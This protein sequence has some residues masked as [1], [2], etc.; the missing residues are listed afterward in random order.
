MDKTLIAELVLG[1]YADD[2]FKPFWLPN[3]LHSVLAYEYSR[4]VEQKGEAYCAAVLFHTSGS[5]SSQLRLH[6]AAFPVLAHRLPKAL[7]L[8]PWIDRLASASYSLLVDKQTG[9]EHH[10]GVRDMASV[11]A[12][13]VQS[14]PCMDYSGPIGPVGRS[15]CLDRH[16]IYRGSLPACVY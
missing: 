9:E 5:P 16:R 2:R 11:G 7:L 12:E 15:K 6:L 14:A 3:R 10:A 4:L 1:T 8:A 13:S